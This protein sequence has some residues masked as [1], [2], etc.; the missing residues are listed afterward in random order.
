MEQRLSESV[1]SEYGSYLQA[2][3]G[4]ADATRDGY[5]KAAANCIALLWSRPEDF[6]LPSGWQWAELDKRAIEIYLN[7]LRDGRGWR[8]ASVRYQASAL[9]A[10]FTFLQ[11]RG[12]IAANPI[13]HLFP[14]APGPPAPPPEGA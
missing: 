3:I 13:R 9:R 6:L 8:P 4:M 1:L 12:H 2:E 7:H 10:F 11:S 14:R 5:L